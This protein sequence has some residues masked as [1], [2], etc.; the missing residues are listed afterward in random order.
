MLLTM[1]SKVQLPWGE[2]VA[3]PR[4]WISR[5]LSQ[6]HI[7]KRRRIKWNIVSHIESCC[8]SCLSC[9]T[10]IG[11]ESHSYG[12]I[13][14]QSWLLFSINLL[15]LMTLFISLF[16]FPFCFILFCFVFLKPVIILIW[17]GQ[18][19]DSH[20]FGACSLAALQTMFKTDA[21]ISLIK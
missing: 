15:H 11:E 21:N 20:I 18:F 12:F 10:K 1:Y 7:G 14:F 4:A 16:A 13:W 3:I 19:G 6:T 9:H 2:S 5:V 17:E 8:L